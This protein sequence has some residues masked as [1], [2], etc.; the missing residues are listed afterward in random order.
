VEFIVRAVE[1]ANN[2]LWGTLSATLVVHPASLKDPQ[3]GPAIERA[4]AELR[5]GTVSLNMLAYYSAYFMVSP[6]GAFPG[7]DIYDIQSGIGK[8]FN[9]LMLERPEKSVTRAP[10]R[11]ID[12]LTVSSKKP[13]EFSKKLADFERSPDWWK[14]PSLAWTALT[15]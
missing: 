4:I 12:P 9:F 15:S 11:R 13:V 14:L 1:F 8:V 5:Y 7:H 6:W 10:F 2:T 3:V